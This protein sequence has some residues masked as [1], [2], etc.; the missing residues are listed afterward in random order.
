MSLI[1]LVDVDFLVILE[2]SLQEVG[3]VGRTCRELRDLCRYD[4]L[5]KQLVDRNFGED[6]PALKEPDESF[7]Q[8][9]KNLVTVQRRSGADYT[10]SYSRG[11]TSTVVDPVREK[12]FA[13]G[14][15]REHCRLMELKY[16]F[17]C[18]DVCCNCLEFGNLYTLKWF[19]ERGIRLVK[20]GLT[21][22][23]TNNHLHILA[24]LKTKGEL[25]LDV[26]WANYA[27]Q[28]GH[29]EILKFFKDNGVLPNVEGTN[30]AAW[31]GR[32]NVLQW[33]ESQE[34]LPDADGANFA[35]GR[36]RLH[37]LRWLA[38]RAILPND[39]GV[40]EAATNDRIATVK[41]L[42]NNHEIIPDRRTAV[43]V[44]NYGLLT[45]LKLLY[46]H[47]VVPDEVI[48]DPSPDVKEWLIDH[49]LPY[50]DYSSSDSDSDY[51]FDSDYEY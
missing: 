34:R 49:N 22:M 14:W 41:W 19:W 44:A 12:L 6:L 17:N 2:L 37:V 21:E 18:E 45:M 31:N 16:S 3:R 10:R 46:S 29:I 48:C 42:I 28:L 1:G 51:A 5:W 25:A 33:L 23:I 26:A 9:H 43:L 11:E 8:Q 15:V 36:G 20:P 27:A 4:G 7:L 24:W 38:E 30:R 47:G 32:L 40:R 39:H 50:I 35:A 13:I